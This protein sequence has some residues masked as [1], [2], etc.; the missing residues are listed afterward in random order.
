M[1]RV[2]LLKKEFKELWRTSRVLIV[3]I[4]FLLLGMQGPIVAKILP[5]LLKNAST[6]IQGMQIIVPEQKAMDAL[7]SYFSQM[8][9]MPILVLILVGM[10]TLAAERERGTQVF[11]L[12]K[13]VTRTQFILSKYFAYL[14]LIIGAVALTTLAVLYYTIL[15]FDSS[16]DMGAYLMLN[17]TLLSYLAFILAMI[18]LCSSFFK[19]SVAAGGVAFLVYLVISL[20]SRFLPNW[21]KYLPEV[22]FDA[23][24]PHSM[25]AGTTSPTELLLPILVGFA[26]AAVILTVACYT[27]ERREM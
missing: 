27:Y 9:F 12:T 4:A 21:P 6:N 2:A 10:G 18:I 15:L 3:V 17:L 13:P 1:T 24:A 23:I 5:D 20:G 14:G 25:L 19:N 22:V 26:L 16:F 11:V 8:S 7:A